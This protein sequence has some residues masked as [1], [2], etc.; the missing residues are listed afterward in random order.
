VTRILAQTIIPVYTDTGPMTMPTWT[1]M[2]QMALGLFLI[3]LI[4]VL[5]WCVAWGADKL[6]ETR[7]SHSDIW[8][9]PMGFAAIIMIV[10]LLWV[11]CV[12]VA[13]FV[14]WAL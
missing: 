11:I 3:A 1:E 8:E 5:P 4:F 12:S 6:R 10:N 7:Y 9:L 14:S 13:H 2:W